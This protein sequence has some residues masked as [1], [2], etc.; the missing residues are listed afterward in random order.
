MCKPSYFPF[1]GRS[2]QVIS[3]KIVSSLSRY[4]CQDFKVKPRVNNGLLSGLM[5]SLISYNAISKN[6]TDSNHYYMRYQIHNMYIS[7]KSN[8]YTVPAS[9]TNDFRNSFIKIYCPTLCWWTFANGP[10][11]TWFQSDKG[12]SGV[13][14]QSSALFA[15]R[16]KIHL[17]V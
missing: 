1:D 9:I 17:F 8:T 2:L 5:S 3:L 15:E 7:H 6:R 10:L 16:S 14:F 4:S 11:K 12:E 13:R